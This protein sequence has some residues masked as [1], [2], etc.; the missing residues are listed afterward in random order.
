MV[1]PLG[2]KLAPLFDVNPNPLE[3]AL[4]LNITEN[5]NQKKLSLAMDT[6]K[7]Y[8]LSFEKVRENT[9]RIAAVEE[10]IKHLEKTFAMLK[11]KC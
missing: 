4:S 11:F 9:I 1:R 7:Y 8:N 2:W 6:A 5:N 3:K 10:E